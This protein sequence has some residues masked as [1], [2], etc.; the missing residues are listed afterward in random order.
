MPS[1]S[2]SFY[3]AGSRAAWLPWVGADRWTRV[4]REILRLDQDL[5]CKQGVTAEDRS[6]GD[7]SR[8]PRATLQPSMAGQGRAGQG[9]SKRFPGRSQEWRSHPV[10][11]LCPEPELQRAVCLSYSG[12]PRWKEPSPAEVARGI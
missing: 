8:V 7:A 5:G 1:V 3:N 4:V 10:P 11:R 9:V 12:P 6:S 2:L